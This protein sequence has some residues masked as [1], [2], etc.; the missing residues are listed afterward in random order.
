MFKAPAAELP[1][2]DSMTSPIVSVK[3]MKHGKIRHETSAANFH[4]SYLPKNWN[5]RD[6]MNPFK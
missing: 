2:A 6:I 5:A 1:I 3:S 4:V